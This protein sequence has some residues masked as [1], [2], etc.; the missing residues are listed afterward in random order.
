M[1]Y[2]SDSKLGDILDQKPAALDVLAKHAGAGA[3]MIQGNIG[4]A[5]GM[6]IAQIAGFARWNA[7]AIDALLADLNAL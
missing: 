2:T 5:R 4:M 3:A 7:E 1:P 6:S